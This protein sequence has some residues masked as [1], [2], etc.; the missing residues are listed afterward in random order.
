MERNLG[1]KI[2]VSVDDREFTVREIL[3][4]PCVTLRW[5]WSSGLC[6]NCKHKIDRTVIHEFY[7][8]EVLGVENIKDEDLTEND[9]FFLG[10]TYDKRTMI[11]PKEKYQEILIKSKKLEHLRK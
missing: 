8:I 5:S 2:K 3:D 7:R 1:D 9:I 4:C 11:F 10:S 6:P